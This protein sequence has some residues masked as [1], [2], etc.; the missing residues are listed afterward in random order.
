MKLFLLVSGLSLVAQVPLQPDPLSA[1]TL[2]ELAKQAPALTV[3]G[4]IVWMFLRH[5]DELDRR[6]DEAVSAV[7]R[8]SSRMAKI[9]AE[10]SAAKESNDD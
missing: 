8:H 7:L 2:L 10:P 1:G 4:W 5:I 6:K 9:Q 3:M